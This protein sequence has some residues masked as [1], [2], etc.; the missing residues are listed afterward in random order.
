[1]RRNY[2]EQAKALISGGADILVLETCQDTRNVKA[3]VLGVQRLMR[4]LGRRV[5]FMISG[6]IEA[7]G[8]MLAGQTADALWSSIAHVDLLSMGLNCATGPEFMTDHL[9]TLS[10]IAS[11]RIS[12]YPNAG[13]PNEEGKY[14]ETPESLAIQL[15]RFVDNAG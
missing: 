7:M 3:G 15:E 2:Y 12:C 4:E 9:R 1:L 8:T 10:E 5:P 13:L 6:T 14:L 11:A